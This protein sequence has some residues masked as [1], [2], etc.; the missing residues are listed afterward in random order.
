M[1]SC[2]RKLSCCAYLLALALLCAGCGPAGSANNGLTLVAFT[3]EWCGPCQADKP[4]LAVIA[5]RVR[6]IEVDVDQYPD[7]ATAYGVT[8]IPVYVLKH[9]GREIWRG[10]TAAAAAARLTNGS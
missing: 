7:L 1:R 5:R 6:V 8:G 9:N 4:T 3:A 10:Q 2:L